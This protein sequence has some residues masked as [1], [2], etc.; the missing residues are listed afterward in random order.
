[1]KVTW[2]RSPLHPN[3]QRPQLDAERRPQLDAE[4]RPQL[5]A[6]PPP[7]TMFRAL[8]APASMCKLLFEPCE[9]PPSLLPVCSVL[10]KYILLVMGPYHAGLPLVRA[11][12]SWMACFWTVLCI[13]GFVL[14]GP[15]LG[16]CG[17][18]VT[19]NYSLSSIL[20]VPFVNFF[21]LRF[22]LYIT[23]HELQPCVVHFV[24]LDEAAAEWVAPAMPPLHRAMNTKQRYER[25]R[26]YLAK[27]TYIL[28]PLLPFLIFSMACYS[29]TSLVGAGIP[30]LPWNH[31]APND[32]NECG[33]RLSY[34]F[35][36]NFI[37]F[38][39]LS[40][41]LSV[42]LVILRLVG[43][44]YAFRIKVL[45]TAMVHNDQALLL[46]ELSPDTPATDRVLLKCSPKLLPLA[47][48]GAGYVGGS[49]ARLGAS[50]VCST[51]SGTALDNFILVY[52]AVREEASRHAFYWSL[53]IISFIAGYA[54]VFSTMVWAVIQDTVRNTT[55]AKGA[56]GVRI[57][58]VYAFL[59]L[60]FL[61]LNLVPVININ[62][63]WQALLKRVGHTWE[64]WSPVERVALCTYF[65]QH[66]LVFPV[67]GLTFTWGKVAGLIG[68][69]LVPLL[70]NE[71]AKQL[72][73]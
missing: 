6:T 64:S 71:A 22:A 66:P 67:I 27:A 54:L 13:I 55:T 39:A 32:E 9:E 48:H 53:P 35:F 19:V 37:V 11:L 44:L 70:V 72:K 61:V 50:S 51:V 52:R 63:K 23:L 12:G 28:A 68:T 57:E 56:L 73:T 8:V 26:Q 5:D 33:T 25:D 30:A 18:G 58:I 65:E 46:R 45:Y 60:S 36:F 38:A 15:T 3:E 16:I 14:G 20:A 29:Y 2:A 47:P 10:H 4:R 1:M 7:D 31:P 24:P 21:T 41:I 62:G 59:A 42:Q 69:A 40:T 17:G 34:A 43:R 49:P